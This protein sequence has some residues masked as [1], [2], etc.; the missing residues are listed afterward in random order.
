M[1]ADFS[2]VQI[3]EGSQAAELGARAYTQGTDIHFAPGQYQP[4]SQSGQE[5][6]GHELAHVVQ[7]GQGRVQATGQAKGVEINDDAKLEHEADMASARAARGEPAGIGGSSSAHGA[8]LQAVQRMKVREVPEAAELHPDTRKKHVVPADEQA[9]KARAAYT[10]S[11]FVTSV[12]VI[13][14]VVNSNDHNFVENTGQA[15]DR[16]D[17]EANVNI[18][19]WNKTEGVGK[20]KPVEKVIDNASTPCEIGVK[21]NGVDKLQVTHFMKK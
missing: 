20:G 1:T 13:T 21:K 10:S 2:T 17:F 11:T 4:E 6:L 14:D 3:H 19:Q 12:D 15:S 18:Y 5:L 8:S 9:E 16:F 7:Q